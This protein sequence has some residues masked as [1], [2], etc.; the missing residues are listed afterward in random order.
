M[1][2]GGDHGVDAGI[3]L[4]TMIAVGLFIQEFPFGITRYPMVGERTTEPIFGE[5]TRGII[6]I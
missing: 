6:I 2:I 4:P 3:D 5:V 1:D